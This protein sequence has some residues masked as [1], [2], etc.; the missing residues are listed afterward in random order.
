M[1]LKNSRY[2]GL[3]TVTDSD[4]AGRSVTAVKFRRLPV[5]TGEETV[6]HDHDKLDVM[7]YQRYRDGTQ[8]WRIADASSELEAGE[9]V[10]ITGRK[11]PVPER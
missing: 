2:S 11:I 9:L 4:A 3:P 1:F 8:F 6:M 5:A 7:A 10:A